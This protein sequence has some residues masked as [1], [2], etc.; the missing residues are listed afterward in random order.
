MIKVILQRVIKSEKVYISFGHS[1]SWY[2]PS[3]KRLVR[4]FR[5]YAL[6]CV[7]QSDAGYIC[8]NYAK[9]YF[10]VKNLKMGD[11]IFGAPFFKDVPFL[12][13]IGCCSSFL[14]TVLEL[15]LIF[16][17]Q[18][19]GNYLKKFRPCKCVVFKKKMFLLCPYEEMSSHSKLH[20]ENFPNFVRWFYFLILTFK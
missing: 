13:N 15:V 17:L 1:K 10:D 16:Q 9:H 8:E 12:T 4:I 19:T 2:F 3:Q 14:D 7:W 18:W 20:M 11:D 5:L 6:L